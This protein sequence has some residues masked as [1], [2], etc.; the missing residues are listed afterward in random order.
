MMKFYD[1][2]NNFEIIHCDEKFFFR[3]LFEQYKRNVLIF[4]FYIA[5]V[6]AFFFLFSYYL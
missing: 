5:I 2:L 6:Y 3:R 1:R 4:T